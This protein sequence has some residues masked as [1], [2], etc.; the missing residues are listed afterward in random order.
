MGYKEETMARID[1]AKKHG[2]FLTMIA[3]LTPQEKALEFAM[4]RAKESRRFPR[5]GSFMRSHS[6][7]MGVFREYFQHFDEIMVFANL[8]DF[9]DIELV[10]E[11]KAG[12]SLEIANPEVL[13][14]P[15]FMP[16]RA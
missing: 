10:A 15:P 3:V 4:S 11:K 2:Y 13:N 7:F 6:A 16:I 8:G 1:L 14:S 12:K 5:D 9:D